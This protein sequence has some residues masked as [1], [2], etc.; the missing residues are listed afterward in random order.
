MGMMRFPPNPHDMLRF[1]WEAVEGVRVSAVLAYET[2]AEPGEDAGAPGQWEKIAFVLDGEAVVV[3]VDFDTDQLFVER[4]PFDPKAPLW[5]PPPA[6]AY[7]VGQR[8]GWAWEV[9][10]Y[11]GYLD[12]FILAFEADEDLS[13]TLAPRCLLLGVA[14]RIEILAIG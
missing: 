10:N 3:S 1:D 7:A 2:P 14:S 5:V 11:R 9:R 8:L 12:G 13:A 6:L 4:L